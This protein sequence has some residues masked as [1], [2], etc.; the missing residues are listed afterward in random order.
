MLL[1]TPLD[2]RSGR[3]AED[4]HLAVQRGD[5]SAR[6]EHSGRDGGQGT[7]QSGRLEGV[8][9]RVLDPYSSPGQNPFWSE[10]VRNASVGRGDTGSECGGAYAEPTEMDIE[11]IKATCMRD[12]E[13][14]FSKS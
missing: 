5:G 2:A 14:A 3:R 7:V 10:G 6:R 9:P 8:A 12:S 1:Q 11:K 13:E 4:R